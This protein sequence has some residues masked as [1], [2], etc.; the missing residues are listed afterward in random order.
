MSSPPLRPLF[1]VVGRVPS[2]GS[3]YA[4]CWIFR[5]HTPIGKALPFTHPLPPSIFSNY[6]ITPRL[7][8]LFSRHFLR[9]L[10][11]YLRIHKKYETGSLALHKALASGT[12]TAAQ[13]IR[14]FHGH[15]LLSVSLLHIVGRVP[16]HCAIEDRTVDSGLWIAD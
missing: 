4:P 7:L 11:V 1:P 15:R 8:P 2:P 16:S 3:S 13:T 14:V 5:V 12:A 6:P 10:H 9:R